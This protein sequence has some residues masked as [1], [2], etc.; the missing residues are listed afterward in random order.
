MKYSKRDSVSLR[1]NQEVKKGLD[2]LVKTSE[3][4]I[5]K[6][7]STYVRDALLNNRLPSKADY[8][9]LAKNYGINDTHT[10]INV[11]SPL[12]KRLEKAVLKS[13]VN[14]AE[15]F[16]YFI[17]SSLKLGKF[18]YTEKDYLIKK[19]KY[20]YGEDINGK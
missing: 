18:P 1:M 2:K 10:V 7:A 14:S 8:D 5:T 19:L 13:E 11:E 17:M 9:A 4:P 20:D 3:I 15:C 16:R 6:Q 12:K